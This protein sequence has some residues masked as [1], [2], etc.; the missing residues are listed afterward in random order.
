MPLLIEVPYDENILIG[1]VSPAHKVFWPVAAWGKTRKD[2]FQ[3]LRLNDVTHYMFIGL[4]A[5]GVKML[6][7]RKV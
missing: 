1:D 3:R 4:G 2:C 7:G 6:G 5:G